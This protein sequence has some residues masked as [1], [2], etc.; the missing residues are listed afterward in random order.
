MSNFL[1]IIKS[2]LD[3]GRSLASKEEYEKEGYGEAYKRLKKVQSEKGPK[4]EPEPEPEHGKRDVW[5]RSDSVPVPPKEQDK[6]RRKEAAKAR[7]LIRLAAANV[8]KKGGSKKAQKAAAEEQRAK[9]AVNTNPHR[10][11]TSTQRPDQ[12][13]RNRQEAASG[14]AAANLRKE[15]A[16]DDAERARRKR[17]EG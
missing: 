8:R 6:I 5:G 9:K 12:I 14:R 2:L 16:D 4:P 15:I 3:E 7:A 11:G 1:N 13:E 10:R 17:A